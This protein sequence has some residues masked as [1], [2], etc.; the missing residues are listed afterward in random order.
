MQNYDPPQCATFVQEAIMVYCMTKIGIY[1][2]DDTI[3]TPD[4]SST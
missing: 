1:G 4:L 2:R 3:Y